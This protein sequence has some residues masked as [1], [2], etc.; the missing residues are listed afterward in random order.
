M[1]PLYG[2]ATRDERVVDYVPRHDGEQTSLMGA[3]SFGRVL[4]ATMTLAGV[5]DTLAFD[6]YLAQVLGTRLRKGDVVYCFGNV[7]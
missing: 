7:A 2:R 1:T 5:V 3:L 6:A 4:L